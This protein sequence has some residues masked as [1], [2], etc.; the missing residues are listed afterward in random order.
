M[1]IYEYQCKACENRFEELILS[2]RRKPACPSCDSRKVQKLF[3]VCGLNIGASPTS[4]GSG[5]CGC[6][7]G[8]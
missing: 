2:P 7:G 8:G 3:S 5:G 4:G 6:G 1:P